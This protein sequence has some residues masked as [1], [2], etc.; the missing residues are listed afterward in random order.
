MRL[1]PM[2]IG[3]AAALVVGV[4]ALVTVRRT[5]PPAASPTAVPGGPATTRRAGEGTSAAALR[6]RAGSDGSAEGMIPGLGDPS[7]PA[8]YT[9]GFDPL[10]VTVDDSGRVIRLARLGL[11]LLVTVASGSGDS[12]R[13]DKFQTDLRTDVEFREGQKVVVGKTSTDVSG[14]SLFLVVS[15]TIGD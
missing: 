11:R 8:R 14:D 2:T 1:R 5:S 6:A 12:R 15:G 4:L 13:I 3:A 7:N 9:I 10:S